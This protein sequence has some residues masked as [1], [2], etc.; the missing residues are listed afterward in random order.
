MF[1]H[2]HHHWHRFRAKFSPRH[3]R[4]GYHFKRRDQSADAR[5]TT[6]PIDVPYVCNSTDFFDCGEEQIIHALQ[7][8]PEIHDLDRD[9][10]AFRARFT[11]TKQPLDG[12][13]ALLAQVPRASLAQQQMDQF[14]HGYHNKQERLFE[15]ID[16]N[17][18][19][20]ATIL[21][22]DDTHRESFEVRAK[23]AADRVCKRVGAP[24]FSNEQWTAIIRGLTREV[25]VYLAARENG[26]D[27]IMTDR[28]HDALGI[29][30]QIQDPSDGRYINTDVKTP[31][32]FRHRM[33]ELVR[34]GRLNDRELLQGDAQSYIVEQTGHGTTRAQVIVLCI[35][36]DKFGELS[37]WRFVDSTSM[38]D[39]LNR[40]I[41]EHGQSD[42][43][44]GRMGQGL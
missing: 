28:A 6:A 24:C 35:L 1:R 29:D 42:G 39:M 30:I 4:H 8:R 2:F 22:L 23:Q 14:P 32:S 25:A 31:S 27:A 13:V 18:T 15:L 9:V 38:R 21:A 11:R 12:F 10:D 17:D 43:G 19:M 26:F 3:H 44:Y 34:E 20:V 33:E 7:R 40:L 37:N 5:H 41:R 16:F 36:P